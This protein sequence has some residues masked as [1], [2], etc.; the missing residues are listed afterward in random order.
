M[1]KR[2]NQI[3]VVEDWNYEKYYIDL[4][5]DLYISFEFLIIVYKENQRWRKKKI[6]IYNIYSLL[7]K[8]KYYLFMYIYLKWLYK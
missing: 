3:C 7:L 8:E 5:V 2:R 6:Y 1:K 4:E